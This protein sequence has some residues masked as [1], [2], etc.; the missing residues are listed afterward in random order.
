MRGQHSN[1]EPGQT[2]GAQHRL[3]CLFLDRLHR[4]IDLDESWNPEWSAE[5]RRLL[6]H[7][8]YSTYHDCVRVGLRPIARAMLTLRTGP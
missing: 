3:Q 7:A 5:E 6:E 4:L 2:D 8:L 1:T